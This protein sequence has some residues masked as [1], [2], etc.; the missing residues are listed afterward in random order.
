MTTDVTADTMVDMM[1]DA[2]A[3]ENAKQA[4]VNLGAPALKQWFAEESLPVAFLELTEPVVLAK[5]DEQHGET[6]RNLS[7]LGQS[8]R[9]EALVAKA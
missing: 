7:L 3:D 9:V 2:M 5:D 6:L 4:D 1:A 8:R